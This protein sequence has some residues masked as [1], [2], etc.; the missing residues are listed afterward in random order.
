MGL[1]GNS[2][3][4]EEGN[5]LPKQIRVR[6]GDYGAGLCP[7]IVTRRVHPHADHNADLNRSPGSSFPW[8]AVAPRSHSRALKPTLP[9]Q[10]WA[11]WASI[12]PDTTKVP[13]GT[14]PF[15]CPF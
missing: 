2:G 15:C 7:E 11:G 4:G 12:A 8:L 14:Q 5:Q 13:W 10:Q 3:G 1:V 9:T 6:G